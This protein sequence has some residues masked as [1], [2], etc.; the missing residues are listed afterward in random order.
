MS[1]GAC[2]PGLVAEGKLP[3]R[4]AREAQALFD[5]LEPVFRR[6]FGDQAA[7][8]MASDAT[9]AQ[10][11]ATAALKRR[12]GLLQVQAQKGLYKR[13]REYDGGD[14]MGT[15][16]I[17]PKAAAA[18]LD[19]DGKGGGRGVEA[20]RKVILGRAHGYMDKLLADHHRNIVGNVRNKAELDDVT[21]ELFQPGSTQNENAR[22]LADAW[23]QAAEYLRQR[24]NAA[25]GN[26]GKLE[27][28]GLPQSHDSLAVHA[29]G[30]RAWK[31]FTA[32]LL[33]RDRMI[34]NR[35]GL[36]FSDQSLDLALSDVYRTISSDGWAK[37]TPGGQ[38]GSG[39]LA[40]SHT[41]HRFL[42]FTDADSWNAY[43]DAFGSGTS[44]D[45]MM[46]HMSAMSR[47][48]A[49]MEVLGPNPD[50]SVQW[51]QDMLNKSA[52]NS[53]AKER[54]AASAGADVVKLL[55]DQYNG[56]LGRPENRRIALGFGAVRA[57]QTSA[58]LGSA[59]LSALPTDPQFGAI[60]RRF[61]GLPVMP[62]LTN[63]IKG[64]AAPEFRQQAVRAGLIAESWATMAAGQ[65]RFLGEE[66]TGE[67]ARRMATGVLRAS[68]LERFTQ[69]GRWA[70][71]MEF[72][73]HV[74]DQVGKGFGDLDPALA[75]SMQRYGIGSDG[76]DR[77]RATA[78]ESDNG[79]DWLY[80]KNIE[81]RELG[82]R[83]LE[84]VQSETDFAVPVADLRTQAR[85]NQAAKRGT[86]MGEVV[87]SAAL[88]KTFGISLMLTQGRRMLESG[89]LGG[90]A[91]LGATYAF[92][93]AAGFFILTTIG[94][95]AALQ[96]KAIAKGQDPRDMTTKEFW[97]ASVLQGGGFGI[98]GDFLSST[99]NR[100]GG[101][102]A[103]TLAGPMA[104]TVNS[105]GSLTYGNAVRAAKGKKTTV[106]KDVVALMRSETPGGSLW[107]SR[108]AF[109]REVLD[110][111]Q[112]VA[113]PDYR[114]AWRRMDKR[115][116][117]AGTDFYWEPGERLPDR[118]PDLAN[119]G[120]Q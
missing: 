95:A 71:G 19:V 27:R 115:A 33:D 16:P 100:F 21:R 106:G 56:N 63:Y 72:L 81:D 77:I 35:T 24:F 40:N 86:W 78:L 82:D 96:L 2:I 5:E 64:M 113:D 42:H 111:L 104:S 23:T 110:Q 107:F 109:E 80:P 93:Y 48:I 73:G 118:A 112:S 114:S 9:I 46:G 59:I 62:M 36:P 15:G 87:R 28:W 94:G 39:K 117:E 37:A 7:A 84:M 25:G 11:R 10:L 26:I 102:F 88:F 8:A 47:D 50:A 101:G 69:A 92:R 3:E 105:V 58:K 119:V 1:L 32:P 51:V 53:G 54:N 85:I 66:L 65:H 20:R 61:N 103:E 41:E 83:L 79:A 99:E 74:T 49:A 70:F 98:F 22:Q 45:A 43:A 18:I 97:G 55:Y 89:Q 57:F 31:E 38:S 14:P 68:G 76:W 116:A 120:G 6:Q 30:E 90:A 29:A 34:D 17:D 75:R 44:F 60:A 12:Q 108:L 91:A 4:S 13:M 52:S 67:V